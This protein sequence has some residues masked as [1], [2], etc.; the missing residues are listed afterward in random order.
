MFADLPDFDLQDSKRLSPK[1][2]ERLFLKIQQSAWF[3]LSLVSA[4]TI[5]RINILNATYLAFSKAMLVFSKKY[6]ISLDEILFII[7][8]PDFKPHLGI[9]TN[10]NCVVKA[11][12]FIPEV[13]AAS[14]M[15]KVLR[16]KIMVS[17]DRVFPGWDF[18]R[19]KGYPTLSHRN[20]IKSKGLSPLHRR[21]F[22]LIW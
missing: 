12:T 16:D 1:R 7:D 18:S 11:D 19:N 20:R 22:N 4:E 15:A 9:K 21:S 10:Y 14:I 13:C 17:Y 3:S 8:G 2:R 5:D 6:K